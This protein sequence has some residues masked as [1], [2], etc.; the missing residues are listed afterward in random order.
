M[1]SF[2]LATEHRADLDTRMRCRAQA[3]ALMRQSRRTQRT[4]EEMQAAQEKTAAV[5][6][7][8]PHQHQNDA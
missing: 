3:C 7:H 5:P 1:D 2:R 8:P 6:G 4:L